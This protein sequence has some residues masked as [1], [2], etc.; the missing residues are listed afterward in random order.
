MHI[1]ITWKNYH[2]CNAASRRYYHNHHH[3]LY[4]PLSHENESDYST[5]TK[6]I[7]VSSLSF[8][9]I[10]NLVHKKTKY[11]AQTYFNTCCTRQTRVSLTRGM[12]GLKIICALYYTNKCPF[13]AECF[14]YIKKMPACFLL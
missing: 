6:K 13:K 12:C 3:Q 9:T 14:Y 5:A 1:Q 10:K 4:F 11:H 8:L 7:F 2:V